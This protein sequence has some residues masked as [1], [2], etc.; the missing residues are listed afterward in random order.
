MRRPRRGH[1]SVELE[2]QVRADAKELPEFS[3]LRRTDASLPGQGLMHV[4]AL[5]EN[6]LEVCRRFPGVLQEVLKFFGGSA[7]V[8]RERAPAVV[9]L[10]QQGQQAQKFG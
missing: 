5:S 1:R 8:R 3:R 6:G 9:I 4:A 10:D 2:K 7:L